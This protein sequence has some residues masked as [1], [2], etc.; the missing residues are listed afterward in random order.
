M[1]GLALALDL[2]GRGAWLEAV[3]LT[4]AVGGDQFLAGPLSGRRLLGWLGAPLGADWSLWAADDSRPFR[5]ASP[6]Q[7]A[8]AGLA[9]GRELGW[10]AVQ[11][12]SAAQER[13]AAQAP[14]DPSLAA[15]P[16][17]PSVLAGFWREV[18]L[19]ASWA[20]GLAAAGIQAQAGALVAG[21]AVGQVERDGWFRPGGLASGAGVDVG[22]AAYRLWASAFLS[23]QGPA[24]RSLLAVTTL[25]GFPGADAALWRADSR[26]TLGAL[27][28]GLSA[29]FSAG[30]YLNPAGAV[31]DLYRCLASLAWR[32][33]A[34]FGLELTL[35]QGQASLAANPV[36]AGGLALD[37]AF[38]LATLRLV[39]GLSQPVDSVSGGLPLDISLDCRLEPAWPRGLRLETA[40]RQSGGQSQRFDVSAAWR[41]EGQLAVD[42]VCLWRFTEDGL[43]IRPALQLGW[44]LWGGDCRLELGL[45]GAWLCRPPAALPSLDVALSWRRQLKPRPTSGG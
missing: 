25:L 17:E 30:S 36:W 2:A 23:S 42:A 9:V 28:L 15:A 20:P 24:G 35:R 22:Q 19:P 45:E 44:T 14:A 33:L 13:S 12:W 37:W 40:W 8:Y 1:A 34:A 29:A 27:V 32:P 39:G 31:A 38:S 10:F 21:R 4:L 26:W 5:L 16:A 11:E 41:L 43:A 3:S 7:A 6:D 18:A